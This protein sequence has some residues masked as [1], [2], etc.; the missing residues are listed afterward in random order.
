MSGDEVERLLASVKTRR[1][2]PE[3]E[4][5]I[6]QAVEA[7]DGPY[8]RVRWWSRAVP[9][10]QAAAACLV[11]CCATLL[12]ARAGG[13]P[14]RPEVVSRAPARANGGR[15]PAQ[16]RTLFVNV[17]PSEFGFG[18]RPVYRLD[19]TRWQPLETR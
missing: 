14:E 19:V 7:T 18:R 6:V 9:L 8:K 5:S 12:L 4:R 2:S 16:P 3:A 11:V 1:L 10:W 15:E 13:T 17:D